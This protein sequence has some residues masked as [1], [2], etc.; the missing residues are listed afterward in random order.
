MAPERPCGSPPRAWGQL[1]R[2]REW[3]LRF[4]FTPT[5]VGTTTPRDDFSGHRSVHPHVRGDNRGPAHTRVY[6][7]RFTPTCVGTTSALRPG[8]GRE[9][10]SPPRAWGQPSSRPPVMPA[11]RFTPTCVGTTGGRTSGAVPMTVH[12]HVRGDNGSSGCW[13]VASVGSPPRAWGQQTAHQTGQVAVRFT[14]T[15]VGTTGSG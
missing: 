11:S 8:D 3:A 12:P 6:D 9:F 2:R 15:C 1:G 14:P 10:G 13:M 5:C 4:R 7:I